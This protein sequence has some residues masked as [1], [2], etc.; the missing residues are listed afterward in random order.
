MVAR[1]SVSEP[2]TLTYTFAVLRSLETSTSVIV[3][4]PSAGI[5]QLALDKV[6]DLLPDELIHPLKSTH[7]LT[8]PRPGRR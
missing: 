5:L 7:A 3:T 1:H 4:K 2:S 6:G 8:A